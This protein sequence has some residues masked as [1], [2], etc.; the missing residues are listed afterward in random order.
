MEEME[1]KFA[2]TI[3]ELT[4]RVEAAEQTGRIKVQSQLAT[5]AAK[6]SGEGGGECVE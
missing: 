1:A 4:A 6:E 3:G 5:V 2:A